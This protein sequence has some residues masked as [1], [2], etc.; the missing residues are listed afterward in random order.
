MPGKH[1]IVPDR[2]CSRFSALTFILFRHS[3]GWEL[4]CKGVV[5]SS[6]D[7]AQMKCL[8][9]SIF[10]PLLPVSAVFS[11]TQTVLTVTHPNQPSLDVRIHCSYNRLQLMVVDFRQ[12]QCHANEDPLS[13]PVRGRPRLFNI[14]IMGSLHA[15]YTAL[16]WP[17]QRLPPAIYE[18]SSFNIRSLSQ[19]FQIHR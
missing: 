9:G 11:D 2:H 13:I 5:R 18:S 3:S 6:Q 14:N 1:T 7:A 12:I 4:L 8:I 16:H 10:W 19:V 15:S 17:R